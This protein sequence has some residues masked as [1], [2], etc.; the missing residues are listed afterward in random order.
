M[1]FLA[2]KLSRVAIISASNLKKHNS[3]RTMGDRIYYFFWHQ[4]SQMRALICCI[5]GI[6][7]WV[8]LHHL[9]SWQIALTSAWIMLLSAYLFAQAIVIFTANG[10]RTQ[11]RVS[12][13][14]PDG[15]LLLTITIVSA[16]LGNV[17]LGVILTEI[18]NR[19]T[20]EIRIVIA[21][22]L[23]RQPRALPLR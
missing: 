7:A 10:L 18:G 23:R 16:I 15:R 17:F 20:T 4:N 21:L 8:I 5:I 14:Q 3:I 1:I 2:S 13:Y 22:S 6:F 12:Q 9:Y 11:Q 19:N